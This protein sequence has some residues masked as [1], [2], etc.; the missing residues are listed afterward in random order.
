MRKLIAT[1]DYRGSADEPVYRR[2]EVHRIEQGSL[3]GLETVRDVRKA[4][5]Y[6]YKSYLLRQIHNLRIDQ[7]QVAPRLTVSDELRLLAAKLERV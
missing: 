5:I 1:F 6:P 7:Q 3:G 4:E 2:V